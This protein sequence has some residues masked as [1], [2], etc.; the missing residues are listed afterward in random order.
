VFMNCFDLSRDQLWRASL[1]QT[2]SVPSLN[3]N[4]TII[5]I[6]WQVNINMHALSLS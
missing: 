1:C 6:S 2:P 3:K 4:C 5:V